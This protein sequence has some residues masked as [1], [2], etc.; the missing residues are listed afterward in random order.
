MFLMLASSR[1]SKGPCIR[2]FKTIDKSQGGVLTGHLGLNLVD[3]LRNRLTHL[4]SARETSK[5]TLRAETWTFSVLV[6]RPLVNPA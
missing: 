3:A 5:K 1:G 4:W 6:F 2:P